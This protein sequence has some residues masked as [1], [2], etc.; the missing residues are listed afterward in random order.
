M[1]LRSVLAASLA[2]G[3]ALSAPAEAQPG[4]LARQL[5]SMSFD[6]KSL[7]EVANLL[8]DAARVRVTLAPEVQE[9]IAKRKNGDSKDEHGPCCDWSIG[10]RWHKQSLESALG[11]VAKS[12]TL[13]YR[14]VDQKTIQI[15]MRVPT[16]APDAP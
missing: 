14:I 2:L 13:S 6:N 3:L 8:S 16:K 9:C 4:I 15:T 5:P 11:M 1:R 12:A 10:A 7:P